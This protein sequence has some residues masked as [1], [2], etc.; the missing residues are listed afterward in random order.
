MIIPSVLKQWPVML[1]YVHY[2]ANSKNM[3]TLFAWSTFSLS[4]VIICCLSKIK[5]NNDKVLL[6]EISAR[7]QIEAGKFISGQDCIFA[8]GE[9]QR[10]LLENFSII[11]ERKTVYL[12]S[13]KYTF[14]QKT[15]NNKCSR[16]YVYTKECIL[17][18]VADFGNGFCQWIEGVQHE[19]CSVVI[20]GREY[21]IDWAVR[22]FPG[23]DTATVTA[24]AK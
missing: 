13:T 24:F 16:A 11:S 23:M 12:T 3:H 1:S 20:D 19:V 2:R 8:A 21:L 18:P 6:R 17:E 7:F 9:C 10:W 14:Q 22:Q 4:V 5:T 15:V